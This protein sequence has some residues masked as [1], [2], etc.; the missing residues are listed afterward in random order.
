MKFLPLVWSNLRQKK[1]RTALTLLTIVVAFILF[2]FL[3]AI[4][5]AMV[6]GIDVA[7]AN[8][9]IVR[10]KVSIIQLLPE[11]Y[12][13]RMERIQGVSLATHQTWFGGAYQE[14]RKSTRLN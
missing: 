11:S 1:V 14:D 4:K 5:E 12:K 13:M 7:G 3:S 8:R 10:H 2:G 6:G 9:M